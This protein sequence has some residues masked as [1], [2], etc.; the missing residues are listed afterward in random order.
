LSSFFKQNLSLLSELP[1]LP[2]YASHCIAFP[3]LFPPQCPILSVM[4]SGGTCGCW[5][6][7]RLGAGGE[8]FTRTWRS[9][10]AR[11]R[12]LL[13]SRSILSHSRVFTCREIRL[14][15]ALCRRLFAHYQPSLR[16]RLG[17]GRLCNYALALAASACLL[18]PS[19]SA[20]SGGGGGGGS[21]SSGSGSGSGGGGDSVGVVRALMFRTV[22]FEGV[23]IG[24]LFACCCA[25]SGR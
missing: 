8:E 22:S 2:N 24:A 7:G 14:A 6:G 3:A 20:D 21:S 25:G 4:S 5:G 13:Y 12:V 10:V 16:R 11:Q 19:S 9:L 23:L 1:P 15:R 17:A 18:H